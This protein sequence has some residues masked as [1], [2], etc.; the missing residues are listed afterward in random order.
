MKHFKCSLRM[1]F[2]HKMWVKEWQRYHEK[3]HDHVKCKEKYRIDKVT[4]PVC[5]VYDDLN[6]HRC[7]VCK[8]MRVDALA[9]NGW[10][11]WH[12]CVDGGLI[13]YGCRNYM[14]D[15]RFPQ[16]RCDSILFDMKDLWFIEFKMDTSS[17]LD[18]V[19]WADM[20]NG[21]RQLSDFI[22]NLRCKMAKKRTPLERY[23]SIKAEVKHQHC[24]ICM[25]KYP[26]MNVFRNNEL[27]KFRLKTGL[28]LQQIVVIPR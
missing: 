11:A 12:I 5:Y 18:S 25:R 26:A 6:A 20:S 28:K 15:F 1:C 27:E 9:V 17:L 10:N 16:G 22:C 2:P 24:T 3:H 21:M 14:E 23:Y 4:S 13:R 8:K 7:Y 19:L